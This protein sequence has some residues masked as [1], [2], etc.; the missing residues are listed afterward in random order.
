MEPNAENTNTEEEQQRVRVWVGYAHVDDPAETF[1]AV[2]REHQR[3]G[4]LLL[5]GDSVPEWLTFDGSPYQPFL[6]REENGDYRVQGRHVL[7]TELD[8]PPEPAL[9]EPPVLPA[10]Y[11]WQPTRRG[12]GFWRLLVWCPECRAVHRHGGG[13]DELPVAGHRAAHCADESNSAYVAVGYSVAKPELVPAQ[14]EN[15]HDY[16][17]GNIVV[18]ASGLGCGSCERAAANAERKARRKAAKC[19]SE[20]ASH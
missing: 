20:I 12:E 17:P 11:Y 7:A 13:S 19:T 1:E 4:G 10:Y 3:E 16:R 2:V 9:T 8:E 14:C 6:W 18:T 15:G 5:V